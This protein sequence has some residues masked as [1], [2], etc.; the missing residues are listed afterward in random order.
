[1]YLELFGL[2]EFPFRLTPDP[3][4]I[5]A[6]RQHSQAATFMDST[7]LLT[8]SFVVI[9]GE[10]GSGKTTLIEKFLSEIDRDEIVTA[11]IF[12]TQVTPVQFLQ[13]LLVEFGFNPFKKRKAEL[14]KMLKDFTIAQHKDGRRV[15]VV[16]DEAQNL[17]QT[18]LEEIRLLSGIETQKEKM[19]SVILVGQPELEEVLNL[20]QMEQLAQRTRLRY[21][22]KALTPEETHEYIEHRL[23]VAGARKEGIFSDECFPIIFKYTGG[24]PR[25]INTLCDT[26]LICCFADQT[27][28]VTSEQIQS[29]VDELGWLEFAQ[30]THT[31]RTGI[32]RFGIGPRETRGQLRVIGPGGEEKIYPLIRGR[33]IIG[34]TIDNDIQIDSEF[35][36][37]HHAQ[38]FTDEKNSRIEDLNSTNGVFLNNRR[39]KKRQLISGDEIELGTHVLEYS[40]TVAKDK[41]SD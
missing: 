11:R 27:T 6:S 36:S 32:R 18:V 41:D 34:R 9:T 28:T 16:V 24:I 20:P 8:D 1:M 2:D 31:D 26:A 17:S 40:E 35:I 3:A 4:F 10:I 25:L 33:L 21:H 37:R 5:Y 14:L 39:I 15:V 30:R 19:L 22:L 12:Q 29:A 13:S 23:K 7:V 38:I